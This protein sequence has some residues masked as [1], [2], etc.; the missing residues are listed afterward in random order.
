MAAPAAELIRSR[1]VTL[2]RCM[3]RF[4]LQFSVDSYSRPNVS[5]PANLR[6][7]AGASAKFTGAEPLTERQ[8]AIPRQIAEGLSNKTIAASSPD[9]VCTSRSPRR[10]EAFDRG[11]DRFRLRAAV[12]ASR[13]AE[14]F[15]SSLER[16]W[17]ALADRDSRED[18]NSYNEARRRARQLRFDYIENTQL[19]VAA[20]TTEPP[21]T[22]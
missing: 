19:V 6:R 15:N 3:V 10:C 4:S 14:K 22:S 2:C 16:H 21:K 18:V 17:K 20:P 12:R 8:D 1:R 7:P 5:E 13:V 11:S 9:R